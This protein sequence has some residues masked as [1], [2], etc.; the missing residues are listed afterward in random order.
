MHYLILEKIYKLEQRTTV[1]LQAIGTSL[2]NHVRVKFCSSLLQ[3]I[4][5]CMYRKTPL[6]RE[7]VIGIANYP[8]RLSP[9]S[10]Y[11]LTV[12]VLHFLCLKFFPHLSNTY[13]EL[14]IKVLFVHKYICSLKQP[15]AVIFSTSNCQI[16]LFFKEKS[17]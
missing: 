9:S 16:Q 7:L 14:C 4:C 8:D 1:L 3:L 6:N 12:I 13:K 11:F 10:K 17:N 15:F 2:L 5:T